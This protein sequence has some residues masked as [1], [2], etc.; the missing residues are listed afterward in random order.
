VYLRMK[1]TSKN[2]TTEQIFSMSVSVCMSVAF[3]AAIFYLRRISNSDLFSYTPVLLLVALAV[4]AG[5]F[6]IAFLQRRAAPGPQSGIETKKT[7]MPSAFERRGSKV[8]L[9]SSTPTKDPF[10]TF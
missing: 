7:E 5:V 4:P 2:F 3:I 8:E 1:T 9:Q 6:G 10:E